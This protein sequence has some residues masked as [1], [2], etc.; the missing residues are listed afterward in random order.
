MSTGRR[1]SGGAEA[2]FAEGL[3]HLV[4]E[5]VREALGEILDSC[6][7][8][9]E[10]VTIPVAASLLSLGQTS[11]KKLVGSGALRSCVVGRRRL[12]NR[13]EITRYGAELGHQSP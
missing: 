5:A 8:G 9:G 3:R 6:P 1:N 13:Q 7:D 10:L 11:V 4:K 12:I 2:V